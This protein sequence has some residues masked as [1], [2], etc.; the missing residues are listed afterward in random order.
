ME[1]VRAGLE[2]VVRLI[3]GAPDG[4][5]PR[6][7]YHTGGY[8]LDDAYLPHEWAT[9]QWTGFLCGR[10]WLVADHFDDDRIRA[11]ATKVARVVGRT[12][13]AQ[14][15]RFSAAGSDLFYAVCLGSRLVGDDVLRGFAL[16]GVRQYSKNFQDRFGVFFQVL[17]VNRAVID[18]GLNLLPFY[19]AADE[20][21]DL[22]DLAL[23]HTSTLL[24]G[25]IIRDDGSSFQALDFDET[26]TKPR[27][28]Y[29]MQGFSEDSTWSRG[30]SWAMHGYVNAFEA[31]GSSVYRD[32]A[33]RVC[34]WYVDHLPSDG[35]PYYDFDDTAAPR[36]PRD[37]CSAAI[38]ANALMKLAQLDPDSG[39]ADHAAA[40]LVDT[41]LSRCLSPGGVLLH[42][43]WGRLPP[44]KAGAAISRFPQED[45]MPYGQYWI[46]E[47]LYRQLHEDWSPLALSTSR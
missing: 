10:L 20:R 43:S 44:G 14:P 2:P 12:L 18:T 30:Q 26:T 5:V 36:V 23:R 34:R 41:L 38:A 11:A 6:F 40:A 32:V 46:V 24:E 47:A 25:G 33:R 28:R 15:P 42:G 45:V 39:W 1:T 21:P 35:L 16:D 37:S 3:E 29:N 8:D 22:R 17:G 13:S 27:R 7:S 31:T 19:W 4:A 9:F